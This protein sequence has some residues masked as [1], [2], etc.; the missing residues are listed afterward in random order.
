MSEFRLTVLPSGGV[1]V[2]GDN[3][4]EVIEYAA[5]LLNEI[6]DK[7]AV[8]MDGSRDKLVR[9]MLVKSCVGCPFRWWHTEGGSTCD[10]PTGPR[11]KLPEP[12]ETLPTP[13]PKWCPLRE[14]ETIVRYSKEFDE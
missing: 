1:V 10:H 13:S 2:D 8:K 7:K 11:V 4:R 3:S 9:V 14:E 12:H 6:T 5:E